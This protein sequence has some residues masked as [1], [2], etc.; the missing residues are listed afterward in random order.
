MERGCVEETDK[1]VTLRM[2]LRELDEG[3]G[4]ICEE[5]LYVSDETGLVVGGATGVVEQVEGCA[6]V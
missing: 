5:G 3:V 4:R 1:P 6:K 2:D